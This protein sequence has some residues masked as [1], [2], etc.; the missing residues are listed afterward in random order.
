MKA[1]TPKGGSMGDNKKPFSPAPTMKGPDSRD[2]GGTEMTADNKGT[3]PD[4]AKPGV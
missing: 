4:R 3:G 2:A 1:P